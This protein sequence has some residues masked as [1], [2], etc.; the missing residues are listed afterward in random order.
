MNVTQRV[1]TPNQANSLA[2]KKKKKA[3]TVSVAKK[4][5]NKNHAN[6]LSSWERPRYASPEKCTIKTISTH[7]LGKGQ[8]VCHQN[9]AQQKPCQLTH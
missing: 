1:Y 4:G 8:D 7:C 2:E 3:K 9:N 5:H 6:S